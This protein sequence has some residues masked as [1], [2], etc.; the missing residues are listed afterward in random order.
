MS[1]PF[2]REQA[3]ELLK[4]YNKTESLLRHAYAVEAAMGHFAAFYGEDVD[5][6]KMVGLLHDL[7]YELHPDEHCRHTPDML[8]K[9]GFDEAFVHAVLAHGYGLCTD[10]VPELPM[11]KVVYTV[12]ELTGFVTAC[13]LVRPSKSLSD[14]EV[15]S[16]KK[17][18]KDPAFAAKVDRDL[19]RGGCEKMGMELDAVIGH[20]IEALRPISKELGLSE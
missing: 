19:I 1:L 11:E 14:L 9:A 7:D 6:W 13:A 2:N 4:T 3:L 16:V 17:K 15:K 12:D 8:R 5:Y 10:T 20:V 18:F